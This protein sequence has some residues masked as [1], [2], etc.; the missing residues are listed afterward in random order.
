MELITLIYVSSSVTLLKKSEILDILNKSRDA[1]G[2]K[3]ITGI[4]LYKSGNFMQVLEG[5]PAVV[6]ELHRKISR[7]PRH[8]GII[9]LMRKPIINRSFS[10]WKMGFKDIDECTQSEKS[11]YSDYLDLPLNDKSYV[12]N[13][14][15][16]FLLLE[17]FKKSVR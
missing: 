16:A 14:N 6:D 5:D 7:D 9:T 15:S 12:S 10:D 2:K 4:L 1:N 8:T 17:S 3:G 11:G 13:P